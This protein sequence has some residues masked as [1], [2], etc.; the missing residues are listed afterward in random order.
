MTARLLSDVEYNYKL[1]NERIS[2]AAQK[3]GK[4]RED[5]TFLAA[6]KT[7]DP[8]VINY[9]ISLGLD[10]IG[11]N[12]V[13]E[14]LSKYDKYDL[15]KCSLQFIGHL[16]TNKVRQ[17]VGKVD[18]IQSVDSVKLASEISKQSLKINKKTDVLVE[19]NIGNEEN[20]SG[21]SP[22]QLEE[23]LCEISEF[24]GISVKGLMAI[25][26]ICDNS[27]KIE[28]YFNKMNNIFIDISQKKLDN[29]SMTILSMG[30]SADYYEAILQG[31]NMVRVGSSLFGAR[32]YT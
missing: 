17:I 16:Q 5:I 24:D 30:M 9:A 12:K 28:K 31:A 13:Q 26:P 7:V 2:E 11:E 21:V 29:I 20:K 27:Q 14:L 15:D 25:P 32:N 23:L 4:K 6:T 3:V 22:E 1:I 19:V 18:L 10:H 8:E